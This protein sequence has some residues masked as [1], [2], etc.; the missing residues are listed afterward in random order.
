MS[1]YLPA[2]GDHTDRAVVGQTLGLEIDRIQE[3]S[4]RVCQH[5]RL[6]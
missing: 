2:E 1:M 6:S 5:A 4:A 3:L